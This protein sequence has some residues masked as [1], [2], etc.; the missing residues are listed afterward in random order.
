[1]IDF[2][3]ENEI[4][5][6]LTEEIWGKMTEKDFNELVEAF[7]N[8]FYNTKG[9]FS[10]GFTMDNLN[11]VISTLQEN[12]NLKNAYLKETGFQN[13]L[14]SH[15]NSFKSFIFKFFFFFFLKKIFI[16]FF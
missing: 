15:F 9:S 4:K 10:N 11:S 1:M 2:N 7:K 14:I 12:S 13:S 3:L 5:K 8:K 6:A 16:F